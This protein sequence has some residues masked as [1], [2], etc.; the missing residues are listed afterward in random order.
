MK[1]ILRVLFKFIASV[2]LLIVIGLAILIIFKIPV[3]LTRFKEPVEVL[4]SKALDRP[5]R[6]KESIV[7]STSLNPYFTMKGLVV[8]NPQ[9]FNTDTFFS[10][11]S[12]R[13]QVKLLPLLKMKLNIS[14]IQVEGLDLTLEETASGSVNWVFTSKQG[15]EA[16]DPPG[17]PVQADAKENK[18]FA[19][20]A[21]SLVIE[22]LK[23]QDINVNFYRP[24]QEKPAHFQLTT[25]LGS[26]LPGKPLQLDI[27]GKVSDFE[28]KVDASV[29]SL[30]ELL[31][32]NKSW[33]EIETSIAKTKL[34]FKG[35]INL[36][37]AAR[38]LQLETIIQGANLSSLNDL[39]QVDLPPFAS[40]KLETVLHLQPQQIILEKLVVQTGSSSLQGSGKIIKGENKSTVDLQLRSPLLQIDDFV[41]E[42]WSWSEDGK[43]E[44]TNENDKDAQPDETI[45][46]GTPSKSS[47]RQIL[48]PE[49]LAKFECS[50]VVEAEKVLSGPDN[51][52]NGELHASLNK[53]RLKIDPLM[54]HLPVGKIDLIASLKPGLVK[55]DAELKAKIENF[56]IGILVRRSKPESEMGGLI[57]LDMYLQSSASSIDDLLATGNGYFDFSGDLEK[58]SAGIIDLWAVN[59][60]ATIVSN[61]TKDESELNC[62]VGRWSVVDGFLRP[63]A[64][65]IDT[66]KIRICTDGEIDFKEKRIDLKVEPHAKRPEFFSLSTP[67]ELHGSFSDINVGIGDAG[68]I[69]NAIKFLAS[70]VSVPLKRTF[71]KK[72]PADGSDVCSMALGPD[73]REDIQVPLCK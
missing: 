42:N 28:Y 59:L 56:D 18:L 3:D 34:S 65:F 16:P 15:D 39:L 70:P 14:E 1:T 51:L 68:V 45:A 63:D 38:S 36:S 9:E 7:I 44:E 55:S 5:V 13:I 23:I 24:N 72:I 25:C 20:Q 60:V 73:G 32:G 6:V 35:N 47:N 66:S 67:L 21:D 49:L 69:G 26:M 41:F 2:F 54:I 71:A 17:D 12:A 43:S 29:G 19:L 10:M 11:E 62:A 46:E 57:N 52:G 64:F 53:G 58:F 8:E 33:V 30:E 4:V 22:K 31:E 48:D 40:Y 61:G 50:L 27:G 37:T